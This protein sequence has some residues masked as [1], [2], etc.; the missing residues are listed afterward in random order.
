VDN[1]AE[2]RTGWNFFKYNMNTFGGVD[3][4]E[5][6]TARMVKERGL[7]EAFVDI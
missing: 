5:W 2:I 3:G 7:R 4:G 1:P 6:L